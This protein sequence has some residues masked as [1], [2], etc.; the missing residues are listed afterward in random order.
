MFLQAWHPDMRLRWK[1][2]IAQTAPGARGSHMCS[3]TDLDNDGVD[4]VIWGERCI[5]LDTGKELFCADQDSYRGHSD[6]VQPTLDPLSNKWYIYTVRE[7]DRD[8]SP[9]VALFDQHGQCVWGAVDE[10]H[11]DMGWTARLGD[12]GRMIASAI[13]IGHKVCGPDGRFHDSMTEFAFDAISG[14]VMNLGYSTYRTM[15]VDLNGDGYHELV[16]GRA[17]GNG[18]VLNRHGQLIDNIK[19]PV[20]LAGKFL[21]LPGEQMLAYYADG[22]LRVWADSQAEDTDVALARYAHPF[23]QKNIKMTSTGWNLCI[24]GGI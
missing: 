23:Y 2:A 18:E 12:G 22:Y 11:M 7:S 19:A 17:S 24:L 9:R 15:P 20:A 1:H 6:I 13:R 4:E 14:E 3:I 8:V 16:R 10:G 5:E 21:N